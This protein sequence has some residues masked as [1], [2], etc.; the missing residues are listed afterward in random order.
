MSFSK[1]NDV[2]I[3]EVAAVAAEAVRARP[4]SA[5]PTTASESNPRSAS[6]RRSR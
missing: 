3:S 2:T 5:V 6:V 4:P 1:E